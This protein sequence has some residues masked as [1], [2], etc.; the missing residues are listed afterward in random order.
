MQINYGNTAHMSIYE[1][2]DVLREYLLRTKGF[3]VEDIRHDIVSEI[4]GYGT[5]ERP[6][7]NLKGMTFRGNKAS[8]PP[9]SETRTS[10]LAS[11]ISD[12]ES[13]N[14]VER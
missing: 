5:S 6:C 14:I 7:N 1:I 8:A 11:Q 13:G 4:C 9:R 10:S 3:K 2:E 12:I